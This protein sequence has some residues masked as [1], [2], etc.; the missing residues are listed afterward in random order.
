MNED[1]VTTHPAI[2]GRWK[3]HVN[4]W[5]GCQTCP[6]GSMACH[7]VLGRG[8]LPCDVLLVG[9]APG[10]E[11]DAQGLPFIGRSGRLLE[12]AIGRVFSEEGRS[13]HAFVTN[14]VACAPRD[15]PGGK[16][17]KPNGAEFT[18]CSPR[19]LDV[20]DLACP[21]RAVALGRVSQD[22]LRRLHDAGHLKCP[23]SYVYHPA[24]ILRQGGSVVCDTSVTRFDGLV[25]RWLKDL[26]KALF[27]ENL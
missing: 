6:L 21:K 27:G 23:Y 5:Q 14:T 8:H 7:H 24:Y 4:D 25:D 16:I 12:A 2:A 19:L 22:V 13:V 1:R 11:E 26:Q 20:I 17:R 10:S 15:E 9:E 18:A 3:G